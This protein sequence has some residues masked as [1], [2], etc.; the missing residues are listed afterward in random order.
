MAH[1]EDDA[2]IN[3][4]SLHETFPK[5]SLAQEID[6]LS[7]LIM[8]RRKMMTTNKFHAAFQGLTICENTDTK[9]CETHSSTL[10]AIIEDYIKN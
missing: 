6:H 5:V 4:N 3:L 8:L 7:N 2:I 1:I 9:L 10:D